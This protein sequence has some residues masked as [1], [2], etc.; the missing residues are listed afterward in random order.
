MI[1]RMSKVRVLGPRARV[2]EVLGALQDFGLL[3]MADVPVG[4]AL[5]AFPLSARE[6]RLRRQL[7]RIRDDADAALRALVSAPRNSPGVTGPTTLR[8]LDQTARSVCRWRRR[9]E[10]LMA[11]AGA[12]SDER[13][14]LLKYHDV[15]LVFREVLG[16]I[17][18]QPTLVTHAFVLP[19]RERITIDALARAIAEHAGGEI[20]VLTHDLSGGDVALLIVLPS[21]AAER[22]EPVI[23]QAKIPE[24]GVPPAYAGRSLTEAMPLVET[25]L[26]EIQRALDAVQQE[27]IALDQEARAALE[28]ARRSVADCLAER[29]AEARCAATAHAFVLE[30]WVPSS[31]LS[32]LQHRLG[33]AFGNE[34]V[35]EVIR[36]DQ[37][38]AATAPVA[39]SNPPLF[40]PFEAIVRMM[41]L[42]RYGTIDP[43][44]YVAVCFP[45]LFG[46]MLGDVGYGVVL[47]ILATLL[48]ARGKP[49]SWQRTVG[50]IATPCAIFSIIFGFV[51]GEVF[52]TLGRA[53]LPWPPLIDRERSMLAALALTGGLG[54][55]HIVLGLILGTVASWRGE[56]RQAI[57]HGVTAIMLL[58]IVGALL[59]ALKVLPRGFFTP[60]V[61]GV[62]VAFP[63]LILAEGMLAPLEL[64]STVGNVMS[65]ARI[66]ALGTASV[67]MAAV[68]NRLAGAVGSVV[69]GAAFALLFHTVNFALGLFSPTIQALRLHYVE[70]F[71]QFYSPGGEPYSPLAH[72]RAA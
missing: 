41:P 16:H 13:A 14:A 59:A 3:H 67:M 40:R 15:W 71:N 54:F 5:S 33:Q 4:P 44:P 24:L 50:A 42:P 29:D 22:L 45:L 65:Y 11:R 23:A 10:R 57:G 68:A 60:A 46:V 12:L 25:R 55:V 69:V 62:L 70:F 37:W 64:L 28:D 35:V 31:S 30:G 47:G 27:R 26:G 7:D 48:R 63:V 53:W 8:P 18:H 52:G 56:R 1:I 32:E 19:A 36:Q 72:T 34:I 66:M 17:S 9:G 20:T 58:L 49:G 2:R 61:V 51:F 43:T 39:L 21:G 38:S 6:R